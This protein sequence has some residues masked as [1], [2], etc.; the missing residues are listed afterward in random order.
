MASKRAGRIPP[1]II[2]AIN[3]CEDVVLSEE[4]A[5]LDLYR[6]FTSIVCSEFPAVQ[7]SL[8]V[9]L[10]LTNGRGN[11]ELSIT[12]Y[13]TDSEEEPILEVSETVYFGDPRDIEQT[14]FELGPVIFE[15]P[16]EHMITVRAGHERIAERRIFVVQEN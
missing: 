15:A 8:F 9:H 11:V 7:S 10:D 6:C 2:L 13:P 1:P 14:C 12:L 5:V 3:V 4:S 16:G